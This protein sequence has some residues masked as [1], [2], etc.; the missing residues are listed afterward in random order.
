MHMQLGRG[1]PQDQEGTRPGKGEPEITVS[2]KSR[3]LGL[4]GLQLEGSSSP[5][6]LAFPAPRGSPGT[7]AS[8]LAWGGPTHGRGTLTEPSCSL[9]NASPA[10]PP[11]E[12]W[13]QLVLDQVP[14]SSGKS[15]G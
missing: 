14:R 8:L 7:F 1:A 15:E 12:S 11:T 6:T 9:A 2:R 5:L 13:L 10:G 4:L 3:G